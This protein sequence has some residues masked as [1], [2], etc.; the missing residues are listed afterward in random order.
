MEEEQYQNTE[1]KNQT[2][3]NDAWKQIGDQMK[4]L[5]VSLAG[6]FRLAWEK[7]ENQQR[8]QGLQQGL[9]SMVKDVSGAIKES[10]DSSEAKQARQQAEKVMES[11]R[12]ASEQ[13]A[14]EVRPH[15]VTALRQL[16]KELQNIIEK[17]EPSTPKSEEEGHSQRETSQAQEQVD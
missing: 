13:T 2:S 7:E 12:N 17:M 14:H 1:D 5:G 11:V 8:L 9:E 4:T 3:T 16:T 15:V 6:V 10:L